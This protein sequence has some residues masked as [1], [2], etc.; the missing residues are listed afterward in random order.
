MLS[1]LWQKRVKKFWEKIYWVPCAFFPLLFACLLLLYIRASA[2]MLF[3]RWRYMYWRCRH[4]Q[5]MCNC[6]RVG[7]RLRVVLSGVS[8]ASFGVS[9][10]SMVVRRWRH[11]T[12]QPLH[13]V[14]GTVYRTRSVA[15]AAHLWLS[16]NVHSKLTF[17]FSVFINI[18]FNYF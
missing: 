10:T 14:P 11:A 16:S 7:Y 8:G 1:D 9:T 2:A 4:A 15:V 18:V 6:T 3:V 13:R 17:I 5:P 12:W